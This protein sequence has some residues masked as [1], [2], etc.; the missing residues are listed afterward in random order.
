A[1]MFLVLMALG[2]VV[3]NPLIILV[4]GTATQYVSRLSEQAG[5]NAWGWEVEA[6]RGPASWYSEAL[7]DNF[8]F[9]WI[10]LLVLLVSGISIA[11]DPRKRILNIMILTWIAPISLYMLWFVGYKAAHYFIPVFLPG[12]SLI[13]NL[14]EPNI[15]AEGRIRRAAVLGL[16]AA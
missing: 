15:V 2:I 8:G 14:F 11:S 3:S 4:P 5:L 7:R 12:M 9:W 10:Y 1:A 6:A 13:G 16:F